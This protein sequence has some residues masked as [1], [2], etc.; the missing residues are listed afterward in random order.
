[1]LLPG[2][3]NEVIFSYYKKKKL[4]QLWYIIHITRFFGVCATTVQQ[5]GLLPIQNKCFLLLYTRGIVSIQLDYP[6][7]GTLT[8][9]TE[10]RTCSTVS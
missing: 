4:V 3:S 7:R 9:N 6:Y 1:M 10:N 5:M 2:F 8:V